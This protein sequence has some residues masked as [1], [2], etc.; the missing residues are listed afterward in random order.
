MSRLT[1]CTTVS[2]VHIEVM[3]DN[4]LIEGKARDILGVPYFFIDDD[5]IKYWYLDLLV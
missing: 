3:A 2:K 5:G 1:I 4:Y